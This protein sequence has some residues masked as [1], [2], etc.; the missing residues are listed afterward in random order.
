[1]ISTF[2]PSLFGRCTTMGSEDHADD[3]E[4]SR[5]IEASPSFTCPR[6][7]HCPSSTS[8]C[9]LILSRGPTK[10]PVRARQAVLT[11]SQS[12]RGKGGRGGWRGDGDSGRL[13]TVVHEADVNGKGTR[14]RRHEYLRTPRNVTGCILGS[15]PCAPARRRRYLKP[16]NDRPM[17]V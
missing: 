14:P 2:P 1:M 7:T 6:A 13:H 10:M 8:L 15:N 3:D 11:S 9:M 16:C 12:W 4:G 17:S 5:D